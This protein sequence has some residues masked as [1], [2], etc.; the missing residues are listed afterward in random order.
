[1]ES[2]VI[3]SHLI[4]RA[5][6]A[7]NTVRAET[8]AVV[9]AFTQY[10]EVFRA[11]LSLLATM[12]Y[13]FLVTIDRSTRASSKALRYVS[14]CLITHMAYQETELAGQEVTHEGKDNHTGADFDHSRCNRLLRVFS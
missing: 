10:Q 2:P 11:S 13:E 6:S 12:A 9:C 7:G 14:T 5:E 4:I 8:I 3:Q 1:V